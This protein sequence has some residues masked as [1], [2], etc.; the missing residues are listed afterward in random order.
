MTSNAVP[1]SVT[2]PSPN[3]YPNT[4]LSIT[5]ITNASQAKITSVAHGFT[6]AD[7]GLTFVMPLQ[8]QGMLP[9]NGVSG[10]I[11][12]I[13]DA[14]NFTVNINTNFFP[15]Y[16]SGGVLSVLTSEPPT[17]QQGFQVFNRPFQNIA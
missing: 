13:V 2:P 17:E 15:V 8:V 1:P 11:Q 7:V 3:E 9:I 5:G 12:S 16:R 10:L 4:I 14:D 6:S